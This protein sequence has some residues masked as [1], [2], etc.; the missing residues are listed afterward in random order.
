MSEGQTAR[1]RFCGKLYIV[2]KY[3]FEKQ[4][5]CPKCRAEA[6]ENSRQHYKPMFTTG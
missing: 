4:D 5:C 1:C 6:E 3:L 2:Y